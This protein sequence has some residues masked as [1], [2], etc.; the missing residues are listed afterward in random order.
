MIRRWVLFFDR[1]SQPV[2]EEYFFECEIDGPVKK[3]GWRRINL[4]AVETETIRMMRDDLGMR[5]RKSWKQSM[6]GRENFE[7]Q[8]GQNKE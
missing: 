3:D 2:K 8:F 5:A 1:H 7:R 4:I 6:S